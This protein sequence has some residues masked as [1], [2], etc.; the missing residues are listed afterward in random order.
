MLVMIVIVFIVC[1]LPLQLFIMVVWLHPPSVHN[2]SA[3]TFY[4][5]S[6]LLCHWL[7]MAHSFIN[8]F[9]YGFMSNNFKV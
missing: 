8:P 4:I 9:I 5:V 1:W 3:Y 7:A 6:Y 2:A